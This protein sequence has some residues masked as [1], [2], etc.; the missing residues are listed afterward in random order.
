MTAA[1]AAASVAEERATQA[2]HDA[3]EKQYRTVVVEWTETSSHRRVINVPID[4]T[5]S[6][7]EECL[8]DDLGSLDDA[9]FQ[10]L[11]RDVDTITAATEFDPD[12]EVLG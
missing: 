1:H 12:A 5:D 6:D 2:D 11:E 10:S 8:P 7:L 3:L 4:L 9:G